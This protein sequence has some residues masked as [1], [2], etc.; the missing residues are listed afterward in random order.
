MLWQKISYKLNTPSYNK[1]VILSPQLPL[2]IETCNSFIGIA[3]FIC[4]WSVV[5]PAPCQW[6]SN[7]HPRM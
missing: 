6:D 3:L 4:R 5:C 1:S 2:F 7:S